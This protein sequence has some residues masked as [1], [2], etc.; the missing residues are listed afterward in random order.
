MT[1]AL[2]AVMMFAN[3]YVLNGVSLFEHVFPSRAQVRMCSN[4]PIITVS[5]RI[6]EDDVATTHWGW[7]DAKTNTISMI[8]NS[9][10]LLCLCFAAESV[11]KIHMQR[12]E[13]KPVRLIVEAVDG[14]G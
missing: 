4:H 12:G 1:D 13:G 9:Y 3:R 2:T 10:F 8:E 7:L 14:E 11:M 5:V 6:T